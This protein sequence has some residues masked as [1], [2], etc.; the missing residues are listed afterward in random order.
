MVCKVIGRFVFMFIHIVFQTILRF[1]LL[2]ILLHHQRWRTAPSWSC[3]PGWTPL[4]SFA[5]PVP[6][7]TAEMCNCGRTRD[8]FALLTSEWPC[9]TACSWSRLIADQG[10]LECSLLFGEFIAG[11]QGIIIDSPENLRFQGLRHHWINN[12]L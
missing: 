9:L 1:Q 12:I 8:C 4:R 5:L 11:A 10:S 3:E 7:H 2:R 6:S